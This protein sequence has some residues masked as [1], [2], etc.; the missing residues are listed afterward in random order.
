MRVK[1]PAKPKKKSAKKAK[2]GPKE[3]RLIITDDPEKALAELLKPKPAKK[4]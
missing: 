3:E 2:P 4:R 1:M